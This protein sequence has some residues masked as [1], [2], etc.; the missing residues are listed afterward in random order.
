MLQLVGVNVRAL[1]ELPVCHKVILDVALPLA[2]IAYR[3]R[4]LVRCA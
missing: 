1:F 4:A 2:V 3:Y